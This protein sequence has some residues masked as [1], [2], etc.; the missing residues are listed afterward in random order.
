MSSPLPPGASQQARKLR[1]L[2]INE[3][4]LVVL[5]TALPQGFFL[6]KVEYGRREKRAGGGEEKQTEPE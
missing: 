6:V 3:A 2:A 5:I 4:E 1:H